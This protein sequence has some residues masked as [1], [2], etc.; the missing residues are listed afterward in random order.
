MMDVEKIA[1]IKGDEMVGLATTEY[2]RTLKLINGMSDSD[3]E[4]P[5]PCSDWSVQLLVAHMLGASEANASL[6]ENVWQLVR[7]AWRARKRTVNLADGVSSVQV[8]ARKRLSPTELSER[9]N[10]VAERAIKGRR[11]FPRLLRPLR[12]P[13]PTGGWVSAGFLMDVAYTRDQWMHRWDLATALEQPFEATEDHDARIVEDV[14]A[15]WAT[16][17]TSDFTLMLGGPAGG[18]FQ[19]GSGGVQIDIDAVEFCKVL[20]GRSQREM[21][22]SYPVVF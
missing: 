15:H 8:D 22:M 17:H 11:R 19:R 5:T 4:R 10:A 2:S 12:I 21:P 14:V 1:P 20:T 18:E 3:W 16:K 7:G 9:M 13:D 6:R